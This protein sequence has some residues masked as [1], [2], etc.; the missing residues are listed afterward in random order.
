MDVVGW[1]GGVG[2]LGGVIPHTIWGGGTLNTRNGTICMCMCMYV[3][4]SV[5]LCVCVSVCLCVC[6]SVCLCVCVYVCMYVC[7]Y[8]CMC[9]CVYVC[10]CVC[11]YVCM[12]VSAKFTLN[13]KRFRRKSTF[14]L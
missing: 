9:V 4:M 10:M 11:V 14:P 7:V 2:G 12:C 3:C 5:C 8:V 1:G 6:V 13:S